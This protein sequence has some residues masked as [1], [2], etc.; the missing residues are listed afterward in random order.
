MNAITEA[1]RIAMPML[2]RSVCE[3]DPSPD[4]STPEL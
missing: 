1:A 2:V 4:A 3:P